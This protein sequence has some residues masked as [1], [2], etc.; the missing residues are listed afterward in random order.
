MLDAI[1]TYQNYTS[2]IFVLQTKA[3]LEMNNL[4]F[5][6]HSNAYF[7]CNKINNFLMSISFKFRTTFFQLLHCN[8]DEEIESRLVVHNQ[9]HSINKR[10]NNHIA[11]ERNSESP[12]SS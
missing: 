4:A 8:I 9:I 3:I 11:D 6:E 1:S 2:K 10:A 5:N 12:Y 7:K